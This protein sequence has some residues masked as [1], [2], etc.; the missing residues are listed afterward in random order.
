MEILIHLFLSFNV[1][2]VVVS[3]GKGLSIN[4]SPTF[5]VDILS[6]YFTCDVECL[7]HSQMM[8]TQNS[9]EV[10]PKSGGYILTL[11][12]RVPVSLSEGAILEVSKFA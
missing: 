6:A 7:P 9:M 11:E 2:A 5:T 3:Q 4:F 1:V 12:I 8:I 10:H